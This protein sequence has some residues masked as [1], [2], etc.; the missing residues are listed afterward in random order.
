[1]SMSLRIHRPLTHVGYTVTGIYLDTGAP[2]LL[3][4][5]GP[6]A[7]ERYWSGQADITRPNAHFIGR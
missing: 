2:E 5:A 7:I 6:G 1:M 3:S 4:S